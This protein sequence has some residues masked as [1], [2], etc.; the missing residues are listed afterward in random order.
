MAEM[1]KIVHDDYE[2]IVDT[3][4]WLSQDYVLKF[5]VE[6]NRRSKNSDKTNF[7][8]EVGYAIN[9]EYRVNINREIMA[10]LSIESSKRSESGEKINI[11]IGMDEIYFFQYKLQEVVRW[12]TS[13]EYKDLF[14]KQDGR[15]FMPSR[16]EPIRVYVRY[17]S[18]IEFEPAIKNISYNEQ[19]IGV[20]MYLNSDG[21]S[22]FLD[23]NKL[24][25]FSYFISNFNIYQAAITLI[26]Y[27]GRPVN[28][29]HYYNMNAMPPATP[30]NK[31]KIVQNYGFLK[32]VGAKDEEGG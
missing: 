4:F 9:G 20:L 5:N 29:T 6:L 7:H 16:V 11:R 26:N 24:L 14:A 27:L 17:G 2:K 21:I 3:C 18:Y 19:V 31:P 12:F 22:T 25:S 15:I 30:N 23:V 1:V 28:G 13:S 8:K 10:Y 32:R